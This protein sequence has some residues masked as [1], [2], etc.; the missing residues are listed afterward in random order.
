M[1]TQGQAQ[2]ADFTRDWAS[3]KASGQFSFVGTRCAV[4]AKKQMS[5]MF[6][7]GRGRQGCPRSSSERGG[8]S[9]RTTRLQQGTRPSQRHFTDCRLRVQRRLVRRRGRDCQA[10]AFAYGG[11]SG[12]RHDA[13]EGLGYAG[14]QT[15]PREAPP[16]SRC[17]GLRK[18]VVRRVSAPQSRDSQR[19][20]PLVQR[21]RRLRAPWAQRRGQDDHRQGRAGPDEAD[22]GRRRAGRGGPRASAICR[23][24]RTSTTT[25]PAASSSASARRCSGSTPAR[26]ASASSELLRDVGLERAADAHLRK[27]S[28]GMLQRIGIAQALVN[29][30]ELV[31]AR[32]ADDRSRPGRPRRGQAHHRDAS[33]SAARR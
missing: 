2:G 32:R 3:L 5:R 14:A 24:T 8:S 25:S 19:C 33:T 18:T 28:K 9:D 10:R 29:D 20:G 4:I 16:P 7:G 26:G 27:Y 23:R 30:P 17:S 22:G 21:E 6:A 15:K 11:G 12:C 1:I 13:A 31:L